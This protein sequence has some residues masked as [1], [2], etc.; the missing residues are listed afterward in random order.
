MAKLSVSI[1]DLT[2][3]FNGDLLVPKKVRMA[4]KRSWPSIFHALDFPELRACFEARNDQ[5]DR[6]KR[7]VHHLGL[8][9]VLLAMGAIFG[10]AA[11]AWLL[12]TYEHDYLLVGFALLVEA[13]ALSSFVIL[14]VLAFG[15]WRARWLLNRFAAERI[16]QWHFQT[17]VL[18]AEEVARSCASDSAR[19]HFQAQR[20]SWFDEFVANLQGTEDS[21]VRRLL[22]N[23]AEWVHLF[24]EEARHVDTT[25]PEEL[26]QAY[27]RLRFQHQEEFASYKES[28]TVAPSKSHLLSWPPSILESYSERLAGA[29]LVVAALIA[30]LIMLGYLVGWESLHHPVWA[31]AGV[32]AAV[33]SASVHCLQEG[34][35][36]SADRERYREYEA[37]TRYLCDRFRAAHTDLERLGIMREMELTAVEEL[38]G[39]L[40][41]HQKARFIL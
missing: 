4:A 33:A 30:A 12:A 16:R 3:Q 32:W 35:G 19:S 1:P 26:L 27:L 39:F 37:R 15:P 21:L 40:R 9:A 13:L 20:K 14:G 18:R 38:R 8:T 31:I 41:T 23:P 2:H 5:S 29:L 17:L 28:E 34:L 11:K 25:L 10:M 7:I 36:I 24:H 22:E 6:A